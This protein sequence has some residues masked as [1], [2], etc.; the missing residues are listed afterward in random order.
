MC[1]ICQCVCSSTSVSCVGCGRVRACVRVCVY[2]CVCVCVCV[3]VRACVCVCSGSCN[4]GWLSHAG[5]CYLVDMT[6]RTRHEAVDNCRVSSLSGNGRL[7]G[8]SS[9]DELVRTPSLTRTRRPFL[10]QNEQVRS[11]AYC[12]VVPLTRRRRPFFSLDKL[13]LSYPTAGSPP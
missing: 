13:V 8:L 1:C 11:L 7:F 9:Q 3:C 6:L 2:V 12:R 4:T 5:H 10:I